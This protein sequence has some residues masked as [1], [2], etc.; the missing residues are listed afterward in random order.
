MQNVENIFLQVRIIKL[1]CVKN[2]T[3]ILHYFIEERGFDSTLIEEFL[4]YK[5]VIKN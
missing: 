2:Y 5:Y 4:K 3:Y 1:F